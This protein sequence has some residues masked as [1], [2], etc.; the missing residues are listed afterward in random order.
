MLKFFIKK[1]FSMKSFSESS[2]EYIDMVKGKIL[3]ESK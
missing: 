2:S 3:L 1:D